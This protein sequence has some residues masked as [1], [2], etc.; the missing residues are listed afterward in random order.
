MAD[1][2]PVGQDGRSGKDGRDQ[3]GRDYRGDR[4]DDNRGGGGLGPGAPPRVAKP[5]E[6]EPGDR[7]AEGEGSF[8]PASLPGSPEAKPLAI[9]VETRLEFVERVESADARGAPRRT[10]RQVEVAAATING[11]VRPRPRRSGPT[12]LR[13]SPSVAIGLGRRSSPAGP[14]TRSELDL[15]QGPGDP[16]ALASLLPSKSVADR[17]PLADRRPRRQESQRLRRPGDQ[18]PRSDPGD[19]RRLLGPDSAPGDD[20]GSGAGRRGVDGLRRLVH[21]RSQFPT[22]QPAD[23]PSGRDPK[24]GGRSRPGSTSRVCSPSLENRPPRLSSR[25]TTT[26]S[27]PEVRGVRGVQGRGL[28]P[29]QQSPDGRYSL[30]HD[31]DWHLYWDDD[32]QVIL[33]RL[34]R[35]EMV[36]QCNLSVGP[37]AGKGRHQDLDQFRGDLKKALGDRF[38]RFRRRGRGRRRPAREFPVSRHDPGRQ[39]DAQVLWHYYLIAGPEGD[40]L[41]ATF[42]LGLAQ[43]AQF[44][45][46][47]LR[48]IG[49]LE[50]K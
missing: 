24:T 32:R 20:P 49:S 29:L 7:R 37:N 39:G 36:A 34:D 19:P 12:S 4:D 6:V 47:D 10:F 44:A 42:T 11:E 40:Q 31:R 17:R 45:D 16:L 26:P 13:W 46:Q 27:S 22:S 8:K 50:W 9:K 25:S 48:L 15:V 23:P 35:G 14:L 5:G 2:G 43:Q 30:L 41:I 3:G 38:L 1:T 33:K 28:A 21:L 18:R